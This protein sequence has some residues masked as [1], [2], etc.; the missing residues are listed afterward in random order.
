MASGKPLN[1]PK[2]IF[3]EGHPANRPTKKVAK[4]K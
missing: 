4:P 3:P 2:G 1:D